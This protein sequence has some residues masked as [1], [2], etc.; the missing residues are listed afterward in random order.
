MKT[1]I[2]QQIGLFCI[3][4][5]LF[6]CHSEKERS[7]PTSGFITISVDES[8]RPIIEQ[9]ILIFENIYQSAN[10]LPVYT[11]ETEAINLLLKDSVRLAIATRTLSSQEKESLESRKLFAKEIKLA[12]DGIA[13]IAHRASEDSLMTVSQ[14]RQIITG[15]ITHWNEIFPGSKWERLE[16]IFDNRNSSTVRYA[17]DSI[18]KG[19]ELA[20]NLYAQ[21][22]NEQVI[23]Y[24][25]KT[26]G[27]LGI[28]GISWLT[29]K[30]DSTRMSFLK[31]VKLMSLS[32]EDVANKGNSYKPY[33][34]YLALKQYP[35]VRDI[36][37]IITDPR[38]GLPSGFVTFMSSDI[39]QKI[40]LKE[41]IVPATQIVRI[42]N[43]K[44][45]F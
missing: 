37:A 9:E 11:N 38:N 18:C 13:V 6:S 40:I 8:F 39:G 32:A 14:L 21:Q 26:P 42:V 19:K 23:D 41:G 22:T 1:K 15:E 24:V 25:S 20:G 17:I 10:I 2:I 12:T 5:L 44:E 36:Y 16:L 31:Q 43:V 35:L 3:A 4:S 29:N 7:S 27:A 33:Q 28:I 34:A 30:A 45:D